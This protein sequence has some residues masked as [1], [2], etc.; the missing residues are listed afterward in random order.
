MKGRIKSRK[1]VIVLGVLTLALVVLSIYMHSTRDTTPPEIIFDDTEIV[2]NQGNS[3]DILLAGVCAEDD[4]DGAVEVIIENI[5]TLPNG[6]QA[7]VYYI[8]ADSSGNIAKVSRLVTYVVNNVTEIAPVEDGE[9]E[10]EEMDSKEPDDEEKL[11]ER[12]EPIDPT[13]PTVM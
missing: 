9:A 1:I 2:Y 10:N 11:D 13:I 5:Y 4:V 6:T 7:K 8:A 3:Y 12:A